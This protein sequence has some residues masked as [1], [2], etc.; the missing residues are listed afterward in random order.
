MTTVLIVD[1]HPSF[2]GFARQLLEREGFHVVG[3]SADGESGLRAALSLRPEVILMD[4][5]LPD[6]T[7]F[8]ITRRLLAEM[9]ARVVL[10]ST[11]DESDYGDDIKSSGAVGFVP[12]A[13]LSGA[14]I[15]H[16]VNDPVN[17]QPAAPSADDKS[18]RILDERSP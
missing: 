10:V 11:R 12:K 8:E 6:V 17:E 2:R 13:E 5:Q 15:R 4:V 16:L 9:T 3:E 14:R 1:D 7:G 18:V